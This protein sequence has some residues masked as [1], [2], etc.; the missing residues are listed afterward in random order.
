MVGTPPSYRESSAQGIYDAFD[1][2]SNRIGLSVV[3]LLR[4]DG[5][6]L[7]VHGI[8][9]FDGTPI[10]DIKPYLTNIPEEWLRRGRL[11]E[12]EARVPGEP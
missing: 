8:D 1:T 7:R 6:V 3:E 12:A 11:A 4:R 5:S 9:M 10:V 2:A